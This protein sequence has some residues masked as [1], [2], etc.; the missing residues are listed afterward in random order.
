MRGGNG[1]LG[2]VPEE[3]GDIDC[4]KGGSCAGCA[5]RLGAD[6]FRAGRGSGRHE[7]R[8]VGRAKREKAKAQRIMRDVVGRTA[9]R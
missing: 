5:S 3:R 6:A 7:I 2:G 8:G 9:G 4:G 1:G